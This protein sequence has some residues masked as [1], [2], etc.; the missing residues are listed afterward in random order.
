MICLVLF[1]CGFTALAQQPAQPSTQ[2]PPAGIPSSGFPG[3]DHYRASRI[4]IF[5]DDFGQLARYRDAN[6]ALKPPA[7][8]EN[9]VVFFGDSITDIWH[10]DEYF[11]GKPY[12]NRGI[13]G[14]TT[15]QM[16]VRFRQDVIELS[17]KVVVILAGTN[18]IAGNTGPMRL[19]D[20][21]ANYA[22]MAELAR[23][24]NIRVV[25]SSVL[26]VHNYTPQ[27][28]DLFAQRSPEKILALNRWLK[29]YVAGHDG[30]LYVDYFAAMVDGKGLL[31]R[32]LAEDGLHPNAVG[33]KIM[34][35]LAEAAIEK[36][37]PEAVQ[38]V[39]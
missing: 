33:Y 34:A 14:Q 24:N 11:P 2:A 29:G 15:P 30:C 20:I 28:Q 32:D 36:A 16:L 23:T 3:L 7:P 35:P 31:K 18:D 38:P 9:R 19:E 17:P 37:L 21:E 39:H 8:G 25:F 1:I 5:T 10:L 26:P 27:S 4:A 22:S 12:I 13:G 6:A